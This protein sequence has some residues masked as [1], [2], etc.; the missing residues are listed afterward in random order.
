MRCGSEV[1][2]SS[3]GYYN[4]QLVGDAGSDQLYCGAG[5]DQLSCGTGDALLSGEYG[6]DNYFFAQGDGKDV[7]SDTLGH[8]TIYLSG[9]PLAEVYF[10]RD[11]SSLVVRFAS[12]PYDEIRLTQFFDTTTVLDNTGPRIDP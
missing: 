1:K 8:S 7:I 12:S 2:F 3:G 11:G 9:L 4:D 5:D 10:R 6:D